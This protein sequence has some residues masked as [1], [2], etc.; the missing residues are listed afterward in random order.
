M[1]LRRAAVFTHSSRLGSGG[2]SRARTSASK[3]SRTQG[4][5]T[6]MTSDCSSPA[7]AKNTWICS[8]AW[9]S[10]ATTSSCPAGKQARAA[11]SQGGRQTKKNRSTPPAESESTSHASSGAPM[12]LLSSMGRGYP[13]LP[14]SSG[15]KSQQ[16]DQPRPA[17]PFIPRAGES[18]YSSITKKTGFV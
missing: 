1:A 6:T 7:E 12:R 5:V 16:T 9:L 10:S 3:G 17:L 15:K 13:V 11:A 2:P 4:P 8:D 14:V 18:S